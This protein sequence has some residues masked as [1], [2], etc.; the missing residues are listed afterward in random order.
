M[1]EN[2]VGDNWDQVLGSGDGVMT[3]NAGRMVPGP[4]LAVVVVARQ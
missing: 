2:E 3:R 1:D 4:G